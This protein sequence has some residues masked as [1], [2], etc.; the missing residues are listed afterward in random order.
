MGRY[1]KFD[2][3]CNLSKLLIIIFHTWITHSRQ[4]HTFISIVSFD[5]HKKPCEGSRAG[6]TISILPMKTI[7]L[8]DKWCTCQDSHPSPW[9]PSLGL[10]PYFMLPLT[11]CEEQVLIFRSVVNN[12]ENH[13]CVCLGQRIIIL[14]FS[15]I[16]RNPSWSGGLQWGIQSL[17]LLILQLLLRHCVCVCKA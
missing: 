13:C 17:I 7:G 6:I 5:A 15:S 10:F 16:S 14:G 3:I 8:E 9:M 1:A 4:Q 12:S 11:W 2:L